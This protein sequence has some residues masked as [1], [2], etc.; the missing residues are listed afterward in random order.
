LRKL[1][2]I[3]DRIAD[4]YSQALSPAAHL[5]HAERQ[6]LQ[7]KSAISIRRSNPTLSI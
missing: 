2:E 6:I 4:P 1:R 3:K 7:R 5:K